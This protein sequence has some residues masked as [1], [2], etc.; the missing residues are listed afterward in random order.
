MKNAKSLCKQ[1]LLAK[2]YIYLYEG[3]LI[4]FDFV[5]A[6]IAFEAELELSFL[7]LLLLPAGLFRRDFF[8]LLPVLGLIVLGFAPRFALF[9]LAMRCRHT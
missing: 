1:R 5:V 9:F 6:L 8:W 7:E 2:K 3:C 4:Y